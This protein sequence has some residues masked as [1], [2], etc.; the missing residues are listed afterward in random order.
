MSKT[1]MLIHGAW[2]NAH[3]WEGFKARYEAKGYTVIARSWPLDDR[4]PAELRASP[5]P[6]LAKVLIRALPEPP[7][8]IGHSFGGTVTQHLLDLG[9]GV[10]G[11]RPR[12]DLRR[13][14]WVGDHQV[15]LPRVLFLGK[16]AP[17]HDHVAQVLCHAL[18]TDRAVGAG[19]CH[20]RPIHR[21]HA[22]EDLL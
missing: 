8:L 11:Y 19:R 21:P 16:L 2:L 3:S 7:I 13:T 17:R 5:N 22:R 1:I 6:A 4:S 12:P 10:A 14:G 9:L 15:D 18:R 20:V